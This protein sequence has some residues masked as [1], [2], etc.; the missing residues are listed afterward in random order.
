MAFYYLQG[1]RRNY[2]TYW[3]SPQRFGPDLVVFPAASSTSNFALFLKGIC[4][5][6]NGPTDCVPR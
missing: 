4:T 1:A 6:A 5:Q 2:W 3:K